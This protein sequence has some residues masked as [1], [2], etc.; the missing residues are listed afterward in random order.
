MSSLYR[1]PAGEKVVMEYY[2][3]AL[4]YWPGAHQEMRVPT[5]LGETFLMAC[6]EPT[7]EPVILLHGAS[8]NA[9]SWMADAPLLAQKMRVYVPD[10]P[11][12]PGRSAPSR[13]DWNGPGYVEW[14]E[15]VLKALKVQ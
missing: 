14:L 4:A 12:D 6:G 11:G 5:C 1:T 13:P 8:S 9:L 2:N 15:D 3:R 7:A 10:V